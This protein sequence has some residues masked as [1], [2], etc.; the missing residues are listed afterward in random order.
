MENVLYNKYHSLNISRNHQLKEEYYNL[1]L[2]ALTRT[3]SDRS[4]Q[5]K[6]TKEDTKKSD[7]SIATVGYS[8]IVVTLFQ[9]Q[10]CYN[11]GVP[12]LL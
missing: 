12:T 8:K 9:R 2:S 6:S 11:K 3:I 7:N 10:K 4:S 1:V 5:L